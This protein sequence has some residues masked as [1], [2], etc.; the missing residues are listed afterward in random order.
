MF[1]TADFNID[2]DNETDTDAKGLCELLDTFNLVQNVK[3]PIYNQSHPIDLMVISKGAD[4]FSADA[5]DSA[6]SHHLWM[7]FNLLSITPQ[8]Q[9]K[10][11]SFKQR[12]INETTG[13]PFME[14]VSLIVGAE[15]IDSWM[16]L[17]R[18]LK[19]LHL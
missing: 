15:S 18:N 6:L 7:C 12:L 19:P 5:E 9:L 2:A 13:V 10:S 1:I 8:V 11:V 17:I 4:I 16:V 14:T 3:A